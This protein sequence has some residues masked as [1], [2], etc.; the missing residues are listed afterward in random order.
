MKKFTL[1][2]CLLFF[3]FTTAFSQKDSTLLFEYETNPSYSNIE[4]YI[5]FKDGKINTDKPFT[6]CDKLRNKKEIPVKELNKDLRLKLKKN[7]E[8]NDDS[9]F[10]ILNGCKDVKITANYSAHSNSMS[11]FFKPEKIWYN[12]NKITLSYKDKKGKKLDSVK[13]K[14]SNFV[15]RGLKFFEFKK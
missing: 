5:N 11:I 6:Y 12:V 13:L 8:I 14:C 3:A 10:I 2:F 7:K 4:V 1:A 9:Y 15:T